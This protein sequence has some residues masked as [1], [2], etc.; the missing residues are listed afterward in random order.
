MLLSDNY[1]GEDIDEVYCQKIEK[2]YNLDLEQDIFKIRNYKDALIIARQYNVSLND[3]KNDN[4]QEKISR[5]A[6]ENFKKAPF[7]VDYY[8]QISSFYSVQDIY[9]VNNT[10][11]LSSFLYY[12]DREDRLTNFYKKYIRIDNYNIAYP[13]EINKLMSIHSNFNTCIRAYGYYKFNYIEKNN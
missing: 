2:N 6:F 11:Y 10:D 8:S 5:Q 7:E 3:L 4:I 1:N 13:L 9:N 12:I